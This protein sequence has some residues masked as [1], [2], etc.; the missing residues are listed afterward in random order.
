SLVEFA[1]GH[2]QYRMG[3][4]RLFGVANSYADPNTFAATL[5]FSLPLTIPFWRTSQD[6]GVRAL[7]VIYQFLTVVCI[8]LSGSRGAFVGFFCYLALLILA[9]PQRVKL[10]FICLVLIP[11]MLISVPGPLQNRFLTIINPDYGP[12]NAKTSAEGR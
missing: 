3:I 7:L 9:S 12:A 6:T 8:V 5:L 1:N 11:G 2:H 10:G 4:S